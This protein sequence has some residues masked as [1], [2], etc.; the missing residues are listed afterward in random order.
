MD[1]AM[2]GSGNLVFVAGVDSTLCKLVEDELIWQGRSVLIY[3]QR[4]CIDRF[5]E[6]R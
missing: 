2:H 4:G 3:N 5:G 1:A 6:L